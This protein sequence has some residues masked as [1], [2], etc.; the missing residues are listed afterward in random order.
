MPNKPH[1]GYLSEFIRCKCSSDLIQLKYFPNAKEVTESFGAYNA[2]RRYLQDDF[3]LNSKNTIAVVVGDGGRPRTGATFAFRTNWAVHSI[4]PN[5]FKTT[6]DIGEFKKVKEVERLFVYRRRIEKINAELLNIK[7]KDLLIVC[8]HSHASL[9]DCLKVLKTNGK[10]TIIS[11]P[12]CKKDDL[13]IEPTITY[14]DISIN[15]EKRTVNIYKN[16]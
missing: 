16:V 15:S 5:V 11:M 9:S 8:V 14:D 4:D 7:N 3:P 12:C 1:L 10:R 13:N 2:L 6:M